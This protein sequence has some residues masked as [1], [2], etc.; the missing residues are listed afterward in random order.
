MTRLLTQS[1]WQRVPLYAGTVPLADRRGSWRELGS[2][3]RWYFWW[4]E[5]L[6]SGSSLV[7]KRPVAFVDG[8]AA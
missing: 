3:G 4:R 8:G 7:R 2:D 6:P 5:E 1:Q